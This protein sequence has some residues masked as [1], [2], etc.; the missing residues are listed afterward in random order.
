MIISLRHRQPSERDLA[1]LA[2]GSLSVRRRARVE[3]A[4]GSSPQLQ[5]D[6][7]AERRALAAIRGV[8]GERA[9]VALRARLELARDPDPRW[10]LPRFMTATAATAAVAVAA[11]AAAVAVTIGG[12][13][14]GAPT[15]AAAAELGTRTPVAVAAATPKDEGVLPGVTAAGIPFPDWGASFGFEAVGVRRDHLGGRLATTVFYARGGQQIAYTIMSGAPL[16]A[17]A[18][19][20][21]RVWNGVRIGSFL[22]NGRVVVTWV[23]NGHTCV[24]SSQRT[25]TAVLTRLAGWRAA[26]PSSDGSAADSYTS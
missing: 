19:V 7:R 22:T 20:R 13:T 26:H 5:A 1:A 10:R 14:S 17:G 3:R 15:V 9:P 12:R 18:P 24:L 8:A 4:V 6:L 16:A 2:D 23:R 21:E 11:F 25:P